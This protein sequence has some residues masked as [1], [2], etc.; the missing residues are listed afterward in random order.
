MRFGTWCVATMGIL[1][2]SSTAWAAS[3]GPGVSRTL[4]QERAARVHDVR[5]SL[6]L[7]LRTH[8]DFIVGSERL[9]FSLDPSGAAEDLA[10]DS[11]GLRIARLDVNGTIANGAETDG[12]LILPAKL[13]HTGENI[14]EMAFVAPVATAGTAITRF[15]DKDD[16]NEYL[17]SLFVPMDAS[18]AFPCFDQPDLKAQFTLQIDAPAAWTVIG[19]TKP[20]VSE[21]R[22][23]QQRWIFPESKPISTY[24]FAFAAGPW[25]KLAGQPGEP[26]LYVRASQLAKAKIEAP[27]VQKLTAEGRKWLEQYFAQPY[28]FPKY[29]LVLIPG[30]AFG[31]MEHAG[32][33]FLKEE[34]VLFRVAP[35][36]S[37]RFNRDVTVLHELA[38]QWF[39]DLVTMRWFDDLWLKEGF[40]QY[41][42]YSAMAS[43]HPETN[44]W[45]H[46]YES[47]KPAAYGIDETLGTTPIYQD[48]PNLKDAKSAYGAIVYQKAPS[49]LKQLEFRLGHEAFRDGLRI[50]LREHAYSNATWADL[51]DAF[52]RASGQNV[53]SWAD[54]WVLRRGMPEISVAWSCDARGKL[55]KLTLSQQDVLQDGFVW[56]IANEVLLA[57]MDPAGKPETLRVDWATQSYSVKAAIG[58]PCPAYVFSNAGDE[59]Y[60]RFLVDDRSRA[61]LQGRLLDDRA[62]FTP[63]LRSMVWGALWDQVHTVRWAPREYVALVQKNLPTEDD[64]DLARAQGGH[65]I[66]AMHRYLSAG[67][68]QPLA[69]SLELAMTQR[70]LH[71][72]TTDLALIHFRLLTAAAETEAGRTTLKSML[73]GTLKVPGVELRPLDRWNLVGK[74][75]ALGDP[76]APALLAAEQKRDPSGD[77]QKYAWTLAAGRPDPATKASYFAAYQQLPGTPGAKPEDWISS[78][79]GSFNAWNQTE[80][81]APYL[82]RALDQLPEIKK[83]RKIFFLGGWLGA[84]LDGQTSA[85]S[86]EVVKDWTAQPGLDPDLRRKVIEN[87]DELERTVRIRTKYPQ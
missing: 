4:A 77:G 8:Q 46:F 18:M 36:A 24:L 76:D 43:L 57:P 16:G 17:Y 85:A 56:P 87:A 15:D 44:P 61:D 6:Q 31:G 14:V 41:M 69:A 54:A 48:V 23:G 38:H 35:T 26:D 33:T 53:K 65:A 1:L 74:L 29:D 42:A 64:P 75:V 73:A 3:P 55:A 66:T 59:G 78:S 2:G 34:S 28:P 84:F 68:R 10:L 81:T 45:K 63:L 21:T 7:V 9:R 12:H 60:G 72:P 11:R 30:F 47:I 22:E 13:L 25:A 58:R 20:E 52:H 19:N 32:E 5:Y 71:A 39:G 80:L 49:I 67:A 40:A 70:M 83:D 37:E 82:R 51:V 50:Y 62:S 79:L 86:L 27:A